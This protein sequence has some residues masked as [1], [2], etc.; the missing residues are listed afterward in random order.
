MASL[1]CVQVG[2]RKFLCIFFVCVFSV[3][4]SLDVGSS[5]VDVLERLVCEMSFHMSS[6]L[7]NCSLAYACSCLY[8]GSMYTTV[9]VRLRK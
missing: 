3:T 2:V 9:L 6:V 1:L 4:V 7:L 5:V 8:C